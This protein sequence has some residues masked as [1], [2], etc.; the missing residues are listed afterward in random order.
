MTS[1]D[2]RSDVSRH[3]CAGA[4]DLR[5]ILSGES[6]ATVCGE[7]TVSIDHELSAGHAGVRVRPTEDESAG[8]IHQNLRIIVKGNMLKHR[9]EYVRDNLAAKD[10]HLLTGVVLDG[11]H[12]GLDALRFIIFVFNS[13]LRLAVRAETFDGA[14]LHTSVN[15]LAD[16]VRQFQ[17][18]RNVLAGFV[19]SIAINGALIAS[20][21]GGIP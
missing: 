7:T 8:R 14:V 6:A 18:Q 3:V 9:P 10:A 15:A 4:V 19:C 16:I 11:D 21:D 20:A 5:G 17:G 12:D 13:D 2:I 1:D